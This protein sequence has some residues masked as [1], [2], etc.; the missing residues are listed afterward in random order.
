[1]AEV[2]VIWTLMLL[3]SSGL[4]AKTLND[5]HSEDTGFGSISR[6]DFY[7]EI[8]ENYQCSQLMTAVV[9]IPTLMVLIRLK[10]ERDE[11]YI[12]GLSLK[13]P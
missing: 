12:N 10:G 2:Y 3:I 7:E 8:D 1:M 5:L 9:S 4:L 6:C 13:V 11:V